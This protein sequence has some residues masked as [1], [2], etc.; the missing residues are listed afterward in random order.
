M[1]VFPRRLFREISFPFSSCTL[2]SGALSLIFMSIP[3]PRRSELSSEAA[4][5]G[6]GL[7][8]ERIAGKEFLYLIL[9]RF[10]I[11]ILIFF[12]FMGARGF[13]QGNKPQLKRPEAD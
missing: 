3:F 8:L 2:N 12:F 1:T 6:S 5:G 7:K 10:A 9:G 11:A 13:G 4:P